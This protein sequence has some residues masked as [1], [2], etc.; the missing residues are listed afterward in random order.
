[1][2]AVVGALLFSTIVFGLGHG[3]TVDRLLTTGLLYG[4]PMGV[5]FVR[6]DFEHAVG[7]HWMINAVPWLMAYLES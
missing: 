5:V 2:V 6:R 1:M 7:A 4:L 3:W